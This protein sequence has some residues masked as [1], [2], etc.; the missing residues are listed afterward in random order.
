MSAPRASGLSASDV[1]ELVAELAPLVTGAELAELVALP[2]RDLVLYFKFPPT[3]DGRTL[4][5]KLH[6]S[7]DGDL[8]RL[9]LQ[10]ARQER[11]DGPIGPFFRRC[12]E[13]LG[14]ARLRRISQVARD[15]IVLLEF[16]GGRGG[17]RRALVAELVG[18]HSNLVLLGSSEK[19]LDVL[20]P[21]PG[22]SK[23]APRL[24]LGAPWVP[25]PGT[26]RETQGNPPLSERLGAPPADSDARPD[27]A[28]PLS[29]LVQELFGRDVAALSSARARKDLSERVERKLER[30]R[31]HLRGLEQRLVASENADEIRKDGEALLA[32]LHSLPRGAREVSVPDP[33]SEEPRERKIELDPRRSPRENVEL[34][35]ERYKKLVRARESVEQELAGSRER[36][37][38]L[39]ALDLACKDPARD[40]AELEAE[41]VKAGLLEP[42]QV[43]QVERER[44]APEARKP[45]RS[46]SG[47]RGSEIRVG[48]NASD[49]DDLTFHHC[50][51]GDLWL[52]TADCPGS[53]VVL[54]I[55]KNA[56]PD[57]EELL[58]AAH[59]AVHFSPMRDATRANVHVARRKEVHKPRGA[60]PGLVSLSG[61]KVLAVRLQP[62]RV[63]RL[64][65]SIRA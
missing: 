59:L 51:G 7:A 8:P 49:N 43:T 52:H 63:R 24:Q 16:D 35:F 57:A 41:A 25:P 26:P 34:V 58:D 45:Y 11:P 53:H 47:L 39:E 60:K 14:G 10:T 55:D 36:V 30:A 40:A 31:S 65:E 13:E 4:V 20:V 2:P 32:S 44:K 54:V 21:P 56:E 46:Y 28:A 1:G 48:R 42:A 62:E 22:G 5:R 33:W 19:V 3:A 9:F 38:A 27:V 18:R 15:R 37:V 61:G 6:L 64:L 12:A 50:R 17:E 29:F 23:S